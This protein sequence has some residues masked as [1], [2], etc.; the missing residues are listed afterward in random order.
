MEIPER[1]KKLTEEQLRSQWRQADYG[2]WEFENDPLQAGSNFLRH[3]ADEYMYDDLRQ[4][5]DL[6]NKE[7]QRRGLAPCERTYI[8]QDD[9][10][11]N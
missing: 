4:E 11:E 7:L 3:P 5:A 8:E 9:W 10:E 2:M 1:L 6:I